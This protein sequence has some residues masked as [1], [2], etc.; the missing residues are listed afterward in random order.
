MWSL[1]CLAAATSHL[2][3]VWCCP[4]GF[5]AKRVSGVKV[6]D[7]NPGRPLMGLVFCADFFLQNQILFVFAQK[8]P[9]TFAQ[10]F[11]KIA[12]WPTSRATQRPSSRAKH[13]CPALSK[14][15]GQKLVIW[16]CGFRWADAHERVVPHL[17]FRQAL[18]RPFAGQARQGTHT[19]LVAERTSGAD[20]S[21]H[22]RCFRHRHPERVHFRV[23]ARPEVHLRGE[24]VFHG[25]LHV[26]GAFRRQEVQRGV[27]PGECTF[28]GAYS[29]SGRDGRG[30]FGRSWG[31]SFQ[32][33]CA[34]WEMLIMVR[35]GFLIVS[36]MADSA[37]RQGGG[38]F[39]SLGCISV[40]RHPCGSTFGPCWVRSKQLSI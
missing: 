17:D 13:F 34:M 35:P 11:P 10:K 8:L 14:A 40:G 4:R 22:P 1:A 37:M 5:N 15:P 18:C 7:P 27:W 20:T 32:T 12:K 23:P 29:A 6:G 33:F 31:F 30:I 24:P 19:P 38:V 25:E 16:P 28:G 3:D 2:L 39:C 26:L 36:H 21:P 9:K